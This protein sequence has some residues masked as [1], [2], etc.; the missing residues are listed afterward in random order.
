LCADDGQISE[1]VRLHT[2]EIQDLLHRRHAAG[3]WELAPDCPNFRLTKEGGE[4]LKVDIVD[5]VPPPDLREWYRE[6]KH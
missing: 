4:R 6:H 1:I 3:V 2:Q 5:G